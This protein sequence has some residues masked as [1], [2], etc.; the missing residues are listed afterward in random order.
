MA[1]YWMHTG[2]LHV[3][4]AKVSRSSGSFVTVRDALAAFDFRT[5]GVT[6]A[7]YT[8]RPA[9]V[10]DERYLAVVASKR[11]VPTERA[12]RQKA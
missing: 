1:R 4:G 6:P 10:T 8:T 3:D 11:S 7:R 5:V 12:C 2:L 9:A